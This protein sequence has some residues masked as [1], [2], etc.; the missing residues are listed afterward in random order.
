MNREMVIYAHLVT[1]WSK[2]SCRNR[3][4]DFTVL[5]NLQ[6]LPCFI[7]TAIQLTTRGSC[8]LSGFPAAGPCLWDKRNGD[9][10]MVFG[11]VTVTVRNLRSNQI[12]M[13]DW[14]S[15]YTDS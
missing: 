12:I 10:H 13:R 6:A 7:V 14:E 2:Y 5:A 8:D 15:T 11:M 9:F 1:M 3:A 4:K